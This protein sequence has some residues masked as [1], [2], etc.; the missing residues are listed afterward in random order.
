MKEIT[1][2]VELVNAVLHYLAG[3]PY[4]EVYQFMQAIQQAAQPQNETQLPPKK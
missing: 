3:K 2:N 4:A 1:L